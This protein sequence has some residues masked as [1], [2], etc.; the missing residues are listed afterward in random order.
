[1]ERR[2]DRRRRSRHGTSTRL[3]GAAVRGQLLIQAEL[4]A[5]HA[6]APDFAATDWAA[7]VGLYDELA[8]IQDT[9]VV[10][11]NRAVAVAMRDGPAA[12]VALLDDLVTDDALRG[13]TG[14]G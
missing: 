4:A 12:G 8:Q 1:M 14:S 3:T 13:R 10:A 5:C 2:A 9:P 11:L 7:I 6:T